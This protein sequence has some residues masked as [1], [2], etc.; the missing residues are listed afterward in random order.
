MLIKTQNVYCSR[1]QCLGVKVFLLAGEY[2]TVQKGVSVCQP[3]QVTNIYCHP[4]QS[5]CRKS[6]LVYG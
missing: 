1:D 2:I 5:Q 4:D 3:S 6:V